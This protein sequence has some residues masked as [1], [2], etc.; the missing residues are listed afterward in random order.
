MKLSK[1]TTGKKYIIFLIL[2]T[3]AFGI[4]FLNIINIQNKK[5]NELINNKIGQIIGELKNTYPDINEEEIIKLLNSHENEQEGKKFLQAFGIQ[6]DELAIEKLKTSQNKNTIITT[7]TI[8]ITYIAFIFIF[9]IYIKFRQKKIRKLDKYIKKVSQ[10]DYTI[11]L[12][13]YSEDELNELT[14]SLYKIT[15]M[16]KEDSENQNKQNEAILSSVSDISHQL[17]TPL[18]SIQILLDNIVENPAM[19]EI[20]KRKFILEITKQIKTMNFL[21]LALLKLSRLDAGV[22]DFRTEKINMANLIDDVLS[23]LEILTDLKQIKII[24]NVKNNTAILGDYN[25]NKEAILNIIKNAIEHTNE[26]KSVTIT[27]DENSVYTSLKIQDEGE[28]ISEENQKHIFERFYKTESSA[29]N[30]IGI[31]LALAKSIIEKQNG[32]ISVESQIGKGTT[33]IIKYL[34]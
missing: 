31:G 20:T 26:G 27:L 33:F 25:W 28:G 23:N 11:N 29:E 22:V 34:K 32:Y 8:I 9:I 13:E 2:L 12:E 15:V 21:I 4:L 1:N 10:K 16:L 5:T 19:D 17:K 3:I 30:S 14:D 7:I 24:K 6:D 18:T